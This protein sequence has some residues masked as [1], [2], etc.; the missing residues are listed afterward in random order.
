MITARRLAKKSTQ[1]H[2][3]IMLKP[4]DNNEVILKEKERR[5]E[6]WCKDLKRLGITTLLIDNY[7]EFEKVLFKISQKSRGRTVY[8]TGSHEQGSQIAQRLGTLLA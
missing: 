1:E 3:L 6:L 8:V 4:K 5:L 2:Y 7:D